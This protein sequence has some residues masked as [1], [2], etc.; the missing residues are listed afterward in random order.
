[1]KKFTKLLGIVL[2]MAL[3]MS[4]GITAAFAAPAADGSITIDNA[5]K[6]EEYTLYK[7]FDLTYSTGGTST[8]VTVPE[9]DEQNVIPGTYQPVAYSYTKG[10]GTDEFFTALQNAPTMFKLTQVQDTNVYTVERITADNAPSDVTPATDAQ[11]IAFM[12][13]NISK[14]PSDRT[15]STI[16]ATG[17][18]VKW[19]NLA[20]GYYYAA[21]SAGSLVT[22]D[23]TL[24]DATVKEKNS[25]P[26]DDK[27]VKVSS[28]GDWGTSD[29]A[30]IGD[31][32]DFQLTVTDGKGTDS[33]ITLHDKMSSGLTLKI[34]SFAV[35][36]GTTDVAADNYT[37]YVDKDLEV[38]GTKPDAIN[39]TVDLSEEDITNGLT[40]DDLVTYHKKDADTFVIVFKDSYIA[41]LEE[42]EVITITYSAILN[43][44]AVVGTDETNKSKT[45]Y[46]NQTSTEKTVTVKTYDVDI[47][48][49]SGSD[50]TRA[51]LAGAVFQLQKAAAT[52]GGTDTPIWLTKGTAVSGYD[53]YEV[54]ENQ[55]PDLTGLT[56]VK[57]T[58][59]SAI[60]I[61]YKNSSGEMVLYKAFVTTEG[62]KVRIDGLDVDVS[63]K[64]EELRAPQ[65]YNKLAEKKTISASGETLDFADQEVENNSGTELPSTGGI[66]TTIFYVVGSILVVAA[67]VLLITKK[68]MSREG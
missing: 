21:S 51:P 57:D 42:S 44:D 14:L 22:I 48:K 31:T 1:M 35:K 12:K 32:V 43:D 50:S 65:G 62:N 25:I 7:I 26:T 27:K 66:G 53:V 24:K 11:V 17:T 47:L 37:I 61:G 41:S 46:S 20:Y 55:N 68:R 28:S 16:K 8:P 9:D 33:F 10:S 45:D 39:K 58:V 38:N 13:D 6:D 3:V 59:D 34:D 49:Y 54:A 56:E 67:G 60:T 29:N 4:M 63:Y 18:T 52:S 2:I 36:V 23:S 40:G 15:I 64:L 5:I 30:Q 19:E